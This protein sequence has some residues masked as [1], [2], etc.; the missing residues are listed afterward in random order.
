MGIDGIS[1]KITA[2]RFLRRDSYWDFSV[3][4]HKNYLMDG[5]WHH[6]TTFTTCAKIVKF[7][8]TNPPPRM[9]S[10]IWLISESYEMVCK[11]VWKEKMSP[12]TGYGLLPASEIDWE[13]VR[14]LRPNQG[15]P[16]EVPLKPWPG[17]PG[18][19]YTISFR[20][21]AQGRQQMQAESIA[22]FCFFEQ[23][24]W[25]LLEEVMRGCREYAFE[26]NKLCEFTPVDP[27][28]SMELR[29][30]EEEDKLPPGWA[31]YR[32]NTR[33][34]MEAGHVS[35]QWYHQFFG[36]IPESMRRVRE[37]GLW[38]GFEGAV[39]PEFD[40]NIH[41]VGRAG[42]VGEDWEIP[43]ANYHRRTIDW[44]FGLDNAFCCFDDQTEVLTSDGWKLFQDVGDETVA[45]VGMDTK[46]LE[47]QKP[48]HKL[49]KRWDGDL[50]YSE[51]SREGVNFAVTPDHDM[52]LQKLFGDRGWLK[53]K[54]DKL[55]SGCFQFP[56]RFMTDNSDESGTVFNVPHVHK[57]KRLSTNRG[58]FAE[59][60]GLV[61]SEGNI[62]T[63][64][65]YQVRIVQKWFVDEVR[66]VI[67]ATGWNHCEHVNKKGVT[68]FTISSRPLAEFLI[69]NG[70]GE[71][72]RSKRIPRFAMMWDAASL[73]RL[74]KGLM[75]GDGR[76]KF[77]N[78]NGTRMFS[79]SYHTSSVGLASDV[80]EL[81]SRLGRPSKVAT[82]S[83]RGFGSVD[84]L[85]YTVRL[86]NST[87]A[88]V[89]P[90]KLD[91]RKYSGYVYCLTVPNGTLVVRRNGGIPM[92]CGNCLWYCR[93]GAGEIVVY[94]EYYSTDT[95][96]TV[97]E[98][99]KNISDQHP[100]P[101]NPY[102]G[103]TFAD[104]SN[105]N[106]HRIASQFS[107][108]APGYDSINLQ[109]ANNDVFSGIEYTKWLF[110]PDPALAIGDGVAR[111]RLRIHRRCRNLIKQL[112]SYR[113]EQNKTGVRD[114]RMAPVKKDDHAVDA[115]RYGPF[116]EACQSGTTPQ[117][118]ARLHTPNKHG[119]QINSSRLNRS[120]QSDAERTRG[121]RG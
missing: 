98:H 43:P 90:K 80:Q 14:W 102:Y 59:F 17:R 105:I 69:A 66:A 12:R 34:A 37:R 58:A 92:V 52:V 95:R 31:I 1:T 53:R 87:G 74:L 42:D 60:L 15:W 91:R 104:P 99:L 16:H 11:S 3:P 121:R 115:L 112:I 5:V 61:I 118:I 94:D 110:Q 107:Q 83:R 51:P 72:S 64:P 23:F 56:T 46:I 65:N 41:L 82:E 19:N 21:Y 68:E 106:C 10:P 20:S 117:T 25:G 49:R 54:A 75:L 2:V 70:L 86:V 48:T 96:L 7:M 62:N 111:P 73:S 77:T 81:A 57:C 88:R 93:N 44:G 103:V 113:W 50:V 45:T 26:G 9:D 40:T 116:S 119:V 97:I 30:M 76:K 24:P 89:N 109:A 120:P 28:M 78:D 29:M 63:A 108:Y 32:A 71:Q 8:M 114:A 4:G 101:K 55:T 36:M 22:G 79:E 39:Y 85:I 47:W 27:G 67:A 33:C 38:G 6:N 84:S 35:E 18:K 13:R 100:W